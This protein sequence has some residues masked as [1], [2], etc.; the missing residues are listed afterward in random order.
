MLIYYEDYQNHLVFKTLE[1][2]MK[3]YHELSRNICNWNNLGVDTLEKIDQCI[4]Y[5]LE[6]TIDSIQL[7]LR[8]GRINDAWSLLRKYYDA[9]I[10]QTY[11]SLCLKND[12][13]FADKIKR[14]RDCSEEM[15]K[16]K[17][18]ANDIL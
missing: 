8:K 11:M 12:C 1:K 18:M 9:I 4:F 10:L 7:L 2:H 15:P 17:E 16:I 14:W 6:G 3:F 13:H 5:S